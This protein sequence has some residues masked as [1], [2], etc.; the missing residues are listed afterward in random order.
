MLYWRL[1]R[2]NNLLRLVR[3]INAPWIFGLTSLL[4]V[5]FYSA[6]YYVAPLGDLYEVFALVAMYLYMIALVSPDESR[7]DSFFG[8]LENLD[9]GHVVPGGSL[10]WFQVR[11]DV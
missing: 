9:H 10:A 8:S 2:S 7:R 11:L 3:A 1:S 6:S 4:S 5:A